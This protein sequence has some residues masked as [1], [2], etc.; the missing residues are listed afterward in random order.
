MTINAKLKVPTGFLQD[1]TEF[2]LKRYKSRINP[3]YAFA[4]SE[5]LLSSCC[6]NVYFINGYGKGQP[7]IW[8]QVILPSGDIKSK[9]INTWIR[10]IIKSVE[11]YINENKKEGKAIEKI[12]ISQY[13]PESIIR[14]MNEHPKKKWDKDE[15]KEIQ[16]THVGNK[17]IIIVDESSM[18]TE[19][20]RSKDYMSGIVGIDSMIYDGNIPE[21]FTNSFDLQEVPYCY[22][23]KIAATTPV[24][25]SLIEEKDVI[26]GGWNRFDIV[27]GMPLNANELQKHNF[28]TFFQQCTQEEIESEIEN[29][30][31]KL[32]N[33]INAQGIRN[34]GLTDDA[35][36]MWCDYEHNK[37]IEALQL[38]EKDWKRGYLNR[39]AEKALKRAVLYAVSRHISTIDKAKLGEILVDDTE[40]QLA[41]DNQEIY[42]QNWQEFIIAKHA[43]IT[44]RVI[45]PDSSVAKQ[46]SLIS[47]L[48]KLYDV[49]GGAPT[50]REL[51]VDLQ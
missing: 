45:Q 2:L 31:T 18:Q 32:L 27:I 21:R 28:E 6:W 34:V 33:V 35:A 40:M 42:Y 29:Y 36:R 12:V 4:L 51:Y 30:A 46:N 5:V 7:N 49:H 24:I 20:A 19:G 50:L 37:K 16:E 44:P 38:T 47:S 8:I 43:Y 26:Q 13:T 9:P 1:F 14:F 39:M 41:I 10:P 17:G 11:E 48:N 22:K 23:S 15:K 25:Y 3:D